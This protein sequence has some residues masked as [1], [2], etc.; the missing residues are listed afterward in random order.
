M[1]LNT[2]KLLTAELCGAVVRGLVQ[3]TTA[4]APTAA[5]CS[6]CVCFCSSGLWCRGI[7]LFRARVVVAQ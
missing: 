2:Q 1:F 5:L 7:E 3:A 6:R 4:K